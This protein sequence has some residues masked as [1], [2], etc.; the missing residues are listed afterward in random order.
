MKGAY[1]S[2]YSSSDFLYNVDKLLLQNMHN[3]CN[4]LDRVEDRDVC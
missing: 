2:L 1:D 4:V 3:I